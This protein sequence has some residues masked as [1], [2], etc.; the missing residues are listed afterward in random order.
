MALIDTV[1]KP[2]QNGATESFNGKF[3]DECLSVE[4]FRNRTEARIEIGQWW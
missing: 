1:G 4:W 3:Y 2:R